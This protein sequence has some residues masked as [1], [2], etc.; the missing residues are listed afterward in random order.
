MGAAHHAVQKALLEIPQC[1][2]ER[3]DGEECKCF[4]ERGGG[5]E[6][7][8]SLDTD[9]SLERTVSIEM[10]K[11]FA[12]FD[13]DA[14]GS[15]DKDELGLMVKDLR[16][17]G[18]ILQGSDERVMQQILWV[19]DV[20]QHDSKVDVEEFRNWFRHV[21][22]T[23]PANLRTL[24]RGSAWVQAVI[25]RLFRQADKDKSGK[26]SMKELKAAMKEIF[27]TIGC[28]VPQ[29]DEA[30]EWRAKMMASDEN[31]DRQLS[32][33]EW[34]NAMVEL[35]SGLYYVTFTGFENPEAEHNIRAVHQGMR[36]T[37]DH[38]TDTVDHDFHKEAAKRNHQIHTKLQ[39]RKAFQ[40]SEPSSSKDL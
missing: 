40:A 2:S 1:F 15:V 37:H 14:S 21:V 28:A 12:R 4:S 5:E 33:D 20:G 30:I 8:I 22:I 23:N 39:A 17:R 10:D 35:M 32:C 27:K 18:Y 6:Y 31:D 29:G 13:R 24:L 38:P 16:G 34:N 11:L 3:G 7:D 36:S 26:V 9:P 19:Y 25:W